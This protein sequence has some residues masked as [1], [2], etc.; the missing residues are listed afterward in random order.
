[1]EHSRKRWTHSNGEAD[2]DE[3][4]LAN[5]MLQLF[6]QLQPCGAA[7]SGF[8]SSSIRRGLAGAMVENG[9]EN[10]DLSKISVLSRETVQ[11]AVCCYEQQLLLT[12][13]RPECSAADP[14][15]LGISSL[16]AALDPMH[17]IAELVLRGQSEL[18]AR[19]HWRLCGRPEALYSSRN[20]LVALMRSMR[21]GPQL[22]SGTNSPAGRNVEGIYERAANV[23]AS[24]R[25]I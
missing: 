17:L 13:S 25:R 7:L 18:A 8:V 22:N 24:N 3:R 15:R 20:A 23:L 5:V 4:A 1:M 14:S 6:A 9:K 12:Q 10:E 16:T 21:S 19:W 2:T 11:R